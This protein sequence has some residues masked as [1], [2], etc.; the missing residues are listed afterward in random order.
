MEKICE[1]CAITFV[2]DERLK[3][4]RIRRFCSGKCAKSHNGKSNLNRKHS[5]EVNAKKGLKGEKNPFFGKK[6]TKHSK[7]IIGIKNRWE[8]KD[9]NIVNLND[10]EK[11]ILDG[12]MLSDGCLSEY[13]RISSRL[14]FGFKYK[15]M[16][17]SIS[18]N[19]PS[20]MFITPFYNKKNKCW[21]GKSKSY[22]NLLIENKRWY[23]E[24]NKKIVPKDI[25]VT[26]ISCYWWYIGDGY[27]TIKKNVILCTDAFSHN[28]NLFLIKKL[29]DCGFKCTL[30][31]RNRIFFNKKES[32]KFLEWLKNNN[33]IL[34]VY[35]YKWK[36]EKKY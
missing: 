34:N 2:I 1:N 7:I 35:E 9:Y 15:E 6:H 10:E 18:S 31:S 14:T 26:P 27:F 30:T 32:I 22:Y 25:R 8:E 29:N 33:K 11:E 12:I 13:S 23:V 20:L 21:Y 3:R 36:I 16:L 5:N 24:H 28:D 19:L 17:E 4:N